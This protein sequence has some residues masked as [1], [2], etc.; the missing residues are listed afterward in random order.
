ML[1]H[2]IPETY[3]YCDSGS[4]NEMRACYETLIASALGQVS[5]SQ[6]NNAFW[7]P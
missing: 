3:L 5:L 1:T 4:V 7:L 2:L 6:H